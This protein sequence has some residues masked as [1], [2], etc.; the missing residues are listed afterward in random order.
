M[1]SY[2]AAQIPAHMRVE[3]LL[4][5]NVGRKVSVLLEKDYED[6]ERNIFK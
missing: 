1:K 3:S 6:E 5:K 2:R 4:W